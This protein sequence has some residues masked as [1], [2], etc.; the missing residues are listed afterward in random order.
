MVMERTRLSAA[1]RRT[2]ILAAAQR[3]FA[4]RGYHGAATAEIARGAG[5]S[6]PMLYKHFPS[7]Q[8]LFA[9]V[10]ADAGARM[11]ERVARIVE[12]AENPV[13]AWIE[14]IATRAT[15]DPEIIELM[16][17]RML[18]VSLVDVPEVRAAIATNTAAMRERMVSILARARESGY[19][20]DDVDLEAAAWLW[21]GFTLAGGFAHAVD[22]DAAAGNCALMART[23][24]TLLRPERREI[25]ESS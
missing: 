10:L 24:A 9:A 11:G 19:V 23:F 25:E 20:R 4:V 7:K 18:A 22:P 13:D 8:A 6:E 21:F 1:D 12:D 16:R 5:C 15:R 17:L 2:A 14:H 3:E